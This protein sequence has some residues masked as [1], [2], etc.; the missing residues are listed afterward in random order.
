MKLTAIEHVEQLHDKLEQGGRGRYK[1]DQA[2]RHA[3][4]VTNV[5]GPFFFRLLVVIKPENPYFASRPGREVK[6]L[7][8]YPFGPHSSSCGP[9]KVHHRPETLYVPTEVNPLQVD[10]LARIPGLLQALY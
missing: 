9:T 3:R 6:P 10:G 1:H 2:A 7:G 4:T 8:V 5:V